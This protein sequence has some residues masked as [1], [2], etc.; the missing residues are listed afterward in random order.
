MKKIRPITFITLLALLVFTGC[1]RDIKIAHKV[2]RT[3]F[4]APDYTD[5]T[6]P[7]NIAPHNFKIRTEGAQAAVLVDGAGEHLQIMAA[8]GDVKIPSSAWRRM[9]QGCRGGHITFTVCLKDNKG[10]WSSFL[11]FSIHVAREEC[12]PYVA[13]R[14]IEPAYEMWNEMGIYQRNLG[15]FDVKAIYENRQSNKSCVNCHSFCNRD[16]GEM[17]F[18]VRKMHPGMVLLHKGKVELLATKTDSTISPLVYPSWHP[19]ARFVAFST[20]HTILAYHINNKN[21]AEVYDD[22]SDVVVYDV[23]RHTILSSPL[24]SSDQV[25]ETFPTFSPD[26]RTLYF[27]SAPALDMPKSFDKEHYSLC[28][29][30]FDPVRGTFGT[31]VDTLVNC[32]LTGKSVTFPR[33][34]PD[35]RFLM[36][37]YHAYG[38]FPIWHKDADLWM[39]DLRTRSTYPLTALNSPTETDSYHSWSSNSRWVIF[40]S[41]RVDGWYTRLFIGYIDAAGR[42]RKPF[43]LPQETVRTD[44][45]LMKSYN[46][47]E[48]VKGPV[49]PSAYDLSHLVRTQKPRAVTYVTAQ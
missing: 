27:C 23:E 4:I 1:S 45:Y 7:P 36:Y 2:N 33:V 40:S 34:S 19:S 17:L 31:R 11:P 30:S 35:G 48:F 47:P 5:V 37:T 13:Y 38:S 29:I 42:P 18:H 26:G 28:A 21:A 32:R 6:V 39:L 3:A 49:Q 22:A 15:N 44:A 10:V 24:L 12:D 8:D 20:N 43:Q 14:L 41:R 9:M 46:I 25:Y 16:P